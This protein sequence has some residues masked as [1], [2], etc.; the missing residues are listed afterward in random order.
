M[1]GILNGTK[2][3]FLSDEIARISVPNYPELSVD[4]MMKKC[5]N[6]EQVKRY[7]PDFTEKRKVEKEWLWH[8]L[9]KISPDFVKAA[10]REAQKHRADA[11][12]K[13]DQSKDVLQIKPE[14]LEKLAT[15][16]ML[17]S[18]Y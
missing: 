17:R 12:Q 18:K 16:N 8:V 11:I 4:N 3:H 5:K 1:Q 7:L 13:L 14:L 6:H 10:I 9:H 15:I 2:D